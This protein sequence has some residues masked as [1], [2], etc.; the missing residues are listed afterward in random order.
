MGRTRETNTF[1]EMVTFS[2]TPACTRRNETLEQKSMCHS[3]RE[4][5]NFQCWSTHA[6][7]RMTPTL[8]DIQSTK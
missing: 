2:T 3:V 6:L 5:E 7:Y 8:V 4:M 1:R